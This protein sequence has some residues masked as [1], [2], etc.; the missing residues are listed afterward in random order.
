MTQLDELAADLDVSG[1]TL[2]RAAAA[3]TFQ[4]NR[5]SPK[6]PQLP[7]SEEAYLRRGWPLLAEL[8]RLLRTEPNVRLAVL[9]GSRARG[10]DQWDSDVDLLVRLWEA[11]FA[12]R[13]GLAARLE[14][15]L[16]H[17]LQVTLL[18]D[19]RRKPSLLADA[20]EEGRVL[21]D[22]DDEWHALLRRRGQIL[23]DADAD[24]AALEQRAT[25]ALVELQ[26]RA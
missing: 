4:L 20:L 15:A 18:D 1:R 12:R 21:V 3:G 16:G 17:E 13:A 11:D 14:G 7:V 6:R 25:A 19:A 22:R 10:D 2:R 26:R 5:P 8:R 24:D 23:R 9:Y